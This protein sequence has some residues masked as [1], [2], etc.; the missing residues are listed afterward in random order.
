MER[1]WEIKR[2]ELERDLTPEEQAC[3]K[4]FESTTH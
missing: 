1:F 3:E 2:F 4:H